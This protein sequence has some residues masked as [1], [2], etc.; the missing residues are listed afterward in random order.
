MHED[1]LEELA[2]SLEDQVD[3]VEFTRIGS[4]FIIKRM[5]ELLVE[6][7]VEQEFAEKIVAKCE[8][9]VPILVTE[10]NKHVLERLAK[11]GVKAII[12]HIESIDTLN[13]SDNE[14]FVLNIIRNFK[15]SIN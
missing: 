4:F 15:I 10:K 11:V 1:I 3:S 9:Q 6:R 8:I 2:N 14:E 12:K 13:L 5:I 7:E